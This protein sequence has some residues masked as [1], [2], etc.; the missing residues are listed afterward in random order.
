MVKE[1]AR[2]AATQQK[3]LNAGISLWMKDPLSVNASAIARR[4][5]MTH[6]TVLYH[7]GNNIKDVIAKHAVEINNVRIISQLIL[8]NHK[9]VKHLTKEE[10]IAHFKN[11]LKG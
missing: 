1:L 2:S 8:Q 9:A 11:V 4:I 6:A 3:I 7:Y 10:R 5:K